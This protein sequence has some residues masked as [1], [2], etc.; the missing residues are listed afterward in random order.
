M[1]KVEDDCWF[2][3]NKFIEKFVNEYN[4]GGCYYG[5]GGYFNYVDGD[6]V[7]WF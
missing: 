5:D 3:G 4:C 2:E 6:K 7:I 1:I